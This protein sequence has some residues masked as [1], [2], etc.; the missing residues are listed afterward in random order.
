MEFQL[1]YD[2]EKIS[3]SIDRGNQSLFDRLR[4]RR[5]RDLESLPNEERQLIYAIADLRALADEQSGGLEIAPTEIRL[6]HRLAAALDG[7]DSR[8][9]GLPPTVDLTFRTDVE[10][11]LGTPSFR[12]RYEWVK[13]GQRQIPRRVG[14]IL[15][16]SDGPR[17]IPLWLLDAIGLADAFEPGKNDA[18]HWEALARFRQALDPGVRTG[19]PDHTAR[20][21]MT[22]FL[23]GLTVKLADRFSI[24]PTSDGTDFDVV[25]FSGRQLDERR[26]ADPTEVSES[27]GELVGHDLR[28]F[29]SRV[30]D[31]GA[32]PAYRISQG[33]YLVVDRSAAPVL[34]T[35]SQMQ[36]GPVA[37]R[38]AFIRN[39]R[40]AIT[41]AVESAL[42]GEGKLDGL[43]AVGEEDAIESVAGPV[44]VETREFSER[45]TGLK[46]FEK[47]DAGPLEG[48]GTTWLPEDFGRRFAEALAT[49]P[50]PELTAL[51]DQIS[52][53]VHSGRESIVLNDLI[54]PARPEALRAVDTHIASRDAAD[55]QAKVE[56]R[57]SGPI[58]LETA[59]NVEELR[60]IA[61][62][63]PRQAQIPRGLPDGVRTPLKAHQVEALNWQFD[64]WVAGLPG[65]LNADEQ[66][67]GKTLQT[68]AFLRW[69]QI[70]QNQPTASHEGAILAVAPTSLLVNWEQEVARHL[71]EPGLG[72]LVRL[73]G[74][75]MAGRKLAGA[76]GRD[77]EDGEIKIDLGFLREAHEEH[78]AHRFWVL[79]TYTTLTNYQ[80]SLARIPFSAVV[81]D[82]IQALKNP[83]SMRAE[84]ARAIKADFRVGLTGTPIENSAQDLW[85][86]LD[87]TA[88]GSLDSLQ[89]FRRRYSVP[90]A[91]NMAELHQRVFGSRAGAPPLAIRRLKVTVASDL[92]EK[93]RHIHPLAMPPVQERAYEDAKLKLAQGGPGAALKMLHHIRSVSVHPALD[94]S[95]ADS[96][97]IATSA[98]LDATFRIL[99]KIA[100]AE[101]RALVF[102]EHRQMQ[103]RFIEMAKSEFGLTQ[104]DLINGDTP[105]Q[106]RQAI[107]DRFQLHGE[108]AGF[109]VLVLGPK[110]AGTGLTLTAATHVI[111]L[112][113]WWNPAVEEQCNDRVH[114]I[115]Q[116]RP[117]SVH[118]P[119]AVHTGYRESSFDC[120]L[121][122]LMQRKRKLAASALWPMGDTDRDAAELQRM[123][124]EGAISDDGNI[125]PV[126]SA[127]TAMFRRDGVPMPPWEDGGSLRV[128]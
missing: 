6:A 121:Q 113:R 128:P 4:G 102:V 51:R 119:M 21:S 9:L 34:E 99:R 23:S 110:A 7:E 8:V 58:V 20:I 37:D 46:V 112:S 22:D 94:A 84:A 107:V 40:P 45:V 16:T 103:Y 92:P 75:S 31:R 95:A 87:Q 68:I 29:Q 71:E 123:V 117:V 63:S 73:Y 125:E 2:T 61:R 96:D 47:R 27:D 28:T 122:S 82:E 120:L 126:T 32:L 69:L 53:A 50:R 56:D 86:I 13:G 72:H 89:E 79:T 77:I 10:G 19:L 65:I 109:D 90:T 36:R 54:V 55:S 62:L 127:M 60:W 41:Q 115:G 52:E 97:L 1:S 18:A 81:F 100:A 14:A 49:M 25:P 11:V 64:A 114:R 76:R 48:S 111:H 83:F 66:G 118:I 42:R 124:A 67:L 3:L 116:T 105:I 57:I 106:K 5:P 24:S 43:D 30:R 33:N 59:D 91:D 70:H 74:S 93:S 12:L 44:F 39:P 38:R 35:M 17:R 78:R 104:I 80:H 85:A 101:E 88:P 15:E 108:G 26:G 98:R